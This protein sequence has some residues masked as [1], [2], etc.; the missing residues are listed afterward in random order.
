MK[1]IAV[2][3]KEEP[4][5]HIQIGKICENDDEDPSLPSIL[6]GWIFPGEFVGSEPDGG[7][8]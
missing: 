6:E 1:R 3:V 8:C 2:S 5:E 7:M 4:D